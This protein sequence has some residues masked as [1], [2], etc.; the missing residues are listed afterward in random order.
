MRASH[1][2]T[3]DQQRKLFGDV[4]DKPKGAV[5]ARDRSAEEVFVHQCRCMKL[6]MFRREFRFAEHIG[7]GW[8]F[9]F[10]WVDVATPA[11][12]GTKTPYGG[13]KV[14]LE[15]EGLVMRRIGGELVVSG[16]HVTPTGFRSDCEKYATAATMGW[17]VLRFERDQ[18]TNGTAIDYAVEMLRVRGWKS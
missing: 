1:L 2:F 16:R 9:D 10:A 6:P 8:R 5:T 18:V 11:E 15:V 13:L 17:A 7:R 3:A 12:D 14:A 4:V